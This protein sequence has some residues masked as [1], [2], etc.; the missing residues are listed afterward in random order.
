MVEQWLLFHVPGSRIT[1]SSPFYVRASAIAGVQSTVDGPQLILHNGRTVLVRGDA[2]TI[3][4][5]FND[6][7][8][9]LG[10]SAP[11]QVPVEMP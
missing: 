3:A 6:E 7:P 2:E 1:G 4:K 10:T 8:L 5:H 11:P 9:E